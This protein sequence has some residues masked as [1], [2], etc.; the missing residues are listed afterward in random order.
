[1]KKYLIYQ[2]V[3]WL[4]GFSTV[5]YKEGTYIV[6]GLKSIVYAL[7]L[8]IAISTSSILSFIWVPKW[9]ITPHV[10][11]NMSLLFTVNL[12]TITS[13]ISEYYYSKTKLTINQN[14]RT[15]DEFLKIDASKSDKK[16]LLIFYVYLSCCASYNIYEIVS[17]PKK[18]ISW[19]IN[20]INLV[21]DLTVFQIIKDVYLNYVRLKIVIEKLESFKYAAVDFKRT[22]V[23]NKKDKS[24]LFRKE[25]KIWDLLNIYDILTENV[26]MIN[27]GFSITVRNLHFFHQ[28][29]HFNTIL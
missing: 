25:Y 26:Q 8:S 5:K 20:L 23:F 7:I 29:L 6:Q 3:H 24:C 10:I 18:I 2:I 13:W 22:S 4:C 1:M 16:I 14:L 19:H 21:L 9:T 11:A 12:T 17:D 27:G 28:S 15:I